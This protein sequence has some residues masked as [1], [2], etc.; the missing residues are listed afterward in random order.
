MLLRTEFMIQQG[1]NLHLTSGGDSLLGGLIGL[2][3]T[4][5]D[6]GNGGGGC[7]CFEE[8]RCGEAV[9]ATLRKYDYDTVT[10]ERE[11]SLP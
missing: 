2:P 11:N 8:D 3:G 7:G 9:Q 10:N 6:A 5:P 4:G 1:T